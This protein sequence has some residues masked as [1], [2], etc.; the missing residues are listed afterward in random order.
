MDLLQYL[1]NGL[2]DEC[3]DARFFQG[4]YLDATR[5]KGETADL[6]MLHSSGLY[7]FLPEDQDGRVYGTEDLW[8]WVL[9]TDTDETVFFHNPVKRVRKKAGLLARKCKGTGEYLQPV[10]V[11]SET[12]LLSQVPQKRDV[13]IYNVDDLFV[14]MHMR[15]QEPERIDAK[16]LAAIGKQLQMLELLS[17]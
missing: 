6:V 8:N 1:K 2:T 5:G 11:F 15:A 7:L 14:S 4:L 10:V 9:K 3:P 12:A 16:T 17:K 13:E